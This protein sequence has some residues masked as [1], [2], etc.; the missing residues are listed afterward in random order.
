M[1]A[2]TPAQLASVRFSSDCCWGPALRR[3]QQAFTL[4][5]LLV[6]MTIISI[7]ASLILVALYGAQ[8]DAKIARTE[9]QIAKIHEL[10]MTKWEQYETRPVQLPPASRGNSPHDAALYRLVAL[11]EL[12]RRE[13]PDRV[14]DIIDPASLNM[15]SSGSEIKISPAVRLSAPPALQQAYLRRIQAVFKASDKWSRNNEGSECLY[16][17][18]SM[19]QNGDRKAIEFF[20]EDEI[21]DTDLDNMPEILDAW[22]QPIDFLRW[23]P[24]HSGAPL[25]NIQPAVEVAA[26]SGGTYRCG[27]LEPSLDGNAGDVADPF[28]MIHIDPRWRD[29]DTTTAKQEHKQNDPFALYPLIYSGGAD[30]A[31][32]IIRDHD[33]TTLTGGINYSN[34]SNTASYYVEGAPNPGLPNDPYIHL[35]PLSSGAPVFIGNPG[36]GD[37]HLDNISN[38]TLN[39]N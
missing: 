32:N 7:L 25:S 28:D 29:Y 12:Q 31:K 5:E 20:G 36:P 14:S 4:V 16:L 11:R 9:T 23:A 38:H 22:G 17:I 39:V 15:A 1:L 10:I 18:I 33:T 34:T 24:G 26:S 30:N 13:L 2:R 37:E 21:G 27:D 3:R 35:V 8:E 6:T 19:M